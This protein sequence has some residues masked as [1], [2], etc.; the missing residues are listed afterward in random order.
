M[1]V[2]VIEAK[3]FNGAGQR[4]GRLLELMSQLRGPGGCPWDRKQ[5]FDSIKPFTLEE[6]Y[7]VLDAIDARDWPGLCEELGDYLLQAVFYA[8]MAAEQGLFTI[9]DSLDAINEKLVRRHPHIFADAIAETPDD[10]KRR[11]DEIKKAEKTSKGIAASASILAEVP[12]SLPGLMEAEKVSKKAAEAGFDWPEI[13][14]VLD[15]LREEAEELADAR[16][17]ADKSEIEHEIGDLFFTLVN[18][19]RRLDIDPEQA[20]RKTT[21]RFRSRFAHVE[22]GTAALAHPASLREMEELWQEAKQ[23]EGQRAARPGSDMRRS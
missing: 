23:L 17:S 21:G 20:L 19:A 14:G 13:E 6:T 18:L 2:T 7:E 16:K 1:S 22:K 4:F 10:V 11:W 9:S 8:E 12:R 15:K 3:D 5:T